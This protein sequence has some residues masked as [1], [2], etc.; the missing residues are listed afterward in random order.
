MTGRRR[1]CCERSGLVWV[2]RRGE[3]RNKNEGIAAQGTFDNSIVFQSCLALRVAFFGSWLGSLVC[4]GALAAPLLAPAATVPP[5]GFFITVR[6][7]SELLYTAAPVTHI[8]FLASLITTNPT[9]GCLCPTSH[10][11]VVFVPNHRC[12]SVLLL[13]FVVLR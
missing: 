12:A 10:L 13:P 8:P 1:M 2:H 7:K 4:S 6:P 3:S 9:I 5:S 11:G